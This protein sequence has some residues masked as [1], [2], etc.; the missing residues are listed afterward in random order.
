[1]DDLIP[2][3]P[4]D[5]AILDLECQTIAGHTCKVVRLAPSAQAID[6]ERLRERIAARIELAPA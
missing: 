3:G 6:V 1:M 4:E 5:R 2:L